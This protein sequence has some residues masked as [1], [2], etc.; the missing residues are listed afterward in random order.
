MPM[1]NLAECPSANCRSYDESEFSVSM[2]LTKLAQDIGMP[3][4]LRSALTAKTCFP[5]RTSVGSD[6]RKYL[7]ERLSTQI[8]PIHSYSAASETSESPLNSCPERSFT[9]HAKFAGRV[10]W[11]TRIS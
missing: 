10:T 9:L 11:Q 3:L 8:P 5:N 6:A 7:R 2:V 4:T 1:A